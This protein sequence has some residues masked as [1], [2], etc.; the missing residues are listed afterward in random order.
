M[1]FRL[2]LRCYIGFC[3]FANRV[4]RL[5]NGGGFSCRR[6]VLRLF[7][8]ACPAI[9]FFGNGGHRPVAH[10]GLGGVALYCVV[11]CCVVLFGCRANGVF[12]LPLCCGFLRCRCSFICAGCGWRG[13]FAGWIFRLPLFVG[14]GYFGNSVFRLLCLF[15]RGNGLIFRRSDGFGVFRL[16][17]HSD[18]LLFCCG[19][20]CAV[21]GFYGFRL[22]CG[23]GLSGVLFGRLFWG[24]FCRCVCCF[25]GNGCVFRLRFAVGRQM[26]GCFWRGVLRVFRLRLYVGCWGF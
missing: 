22:R 11:L 18:C 9:W 1:I 2:P 21:Y 12:R 14:L 4:F 17:L 20:V 6:F 3:C 19:G 10:G 13:W 8:H 25:C 24:W 26:I 16:P 7:R 5:P 23:F 15:S